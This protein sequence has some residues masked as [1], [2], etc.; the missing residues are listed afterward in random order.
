MEYRLVSVNKEVEILC[1]AKNHK[2]GLTDVTCEITKET[3][4]DE[5]S[6]TT[7]T[8]IDSLGIYKITHTFTTRGEYIVRCDSASYPKKDEV[9]Y[10]V[11]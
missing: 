6:S 7:M 1:A 5:L 9:C 8:E 10:D 2:S 3:A 11:V 4:G